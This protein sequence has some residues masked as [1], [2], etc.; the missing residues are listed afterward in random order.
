VDTGLN[1]M[2]GG[3]IKK[4]QEYVGNDTFLLTYGDGLSNVNIAELLI[5]H[6]KT[7]KH[8][9][10]TQKEAKNTTLLARGD[11][12][13]RTRLQQT[14]TCNPKIHCMRDPTRNQHRHL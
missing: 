14:K 4:I 3:R 9:S 5:N 6:K 12:V 2:T 10:T 13:L 11:P 1:T 7:K 8:R